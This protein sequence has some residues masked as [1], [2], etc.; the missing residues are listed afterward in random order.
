VLAA[1]APTPV[2]AVQP[3]LVPVRVLISSGVSQL[4]ITQQ[5]G[6]LLNDYYGWYL[7]PAL[8]M[9]AAEQL[10]TV[11]L[12]A[13]GATST[14][15]SLTP[16]SLP[17]WA[18][19]TRPGD[20][21]SISAYTNP[22]P[23]PPAF[24]SDALC[25]ALPCAVT[26]SVQVLR[27]GQTTVVSAAAHGGERLIVTEPAVAGWSVTVDGGRPTNVPASDGLLQ[28]TALAGTHTYQ[29]SY[30]T[31]GLAV[32]ALASGTGLAICVWLI[33]QER[34]RRHAGDPLQPGQ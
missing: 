2:L 13:D 5:G 12:T 17:V 1:R 10:A 7:G 34:R 3:S 28:V 22:A 16:L 11:A 19:V 6:A 31:P 20:A 23:E 29:F 30:A 8:A 15:G 18:T 21:H 27:W 32:G 4:A 14:Y 24:L 9:P 26:S 33:W 25:A